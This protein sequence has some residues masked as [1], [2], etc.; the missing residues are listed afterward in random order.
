M[1]FILNAGGILPSKISVQDVCIASANKRMS[2]SILP[3]AVHP[4][5]TTFDQILHDLLSS[6]RELS[7][8]VIVPTLF[9]AEDRKQLFEKATDCDYEHEEDDFFLS[10]AWREL[11]FQVLAKYGHRCHLCG[12]TKAEAPLHVDHIKPRAKHPHLELEFDNLQVLCRDCNM[13][14]LDKFEDDFRDS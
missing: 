5:F 9:N 7:H 10:Q 3:I 8:Q 13:G 11:R 12:A 1:S 6:K 2:T 4:K 14:K